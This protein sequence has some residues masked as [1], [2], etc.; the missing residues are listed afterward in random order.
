MLYGN[1]QMKDLIRSYPILKTRLEHLIDHTISNN[2]GSEG[3]S[4]NGNEL[5]LQSLT[6][7]ISTLLSTSNLDI[8]ESL[9]L[10]GLDSLLA[11]KL[12]ARLK[13]QFGLVFSQLALLGGLSVQ[14]IVESVSS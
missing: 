5:T 9:T 14:Q 2:N 12:S 7:Y 4:L 11:V 13:K 3:I 6:T 8:T 1:F 10:Q